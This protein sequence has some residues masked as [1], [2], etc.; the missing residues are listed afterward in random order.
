MKKRIIK[1]CILT[2]CIFMICSCFVYIHADFW[3]DA[4]TWYSASGESGGVSTE[5]GDKIFG[6]LADMINVI[7]TS[8]IVLVTIA[9]GTKYMF[10]S[11]DSKAD[12]K[13]SLINLLVACVFFFGWQSIKA[14][15]I[16]GNNF[17]FT[18]SGDFNGTVGAIFSTS[19]YIL[20]FLVIV[21]VIYV[22]V[23]YI[24]SG[25]SGRG[26]LKAKSG[27]FLIG[28]ILAFATTN[29]LTFLSKIINQMI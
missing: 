10:G 3:S 1:I 11:V 25:A 29:F 6:G 19:M 15:L 27:N 22:G 23:R 14:I 5:E 21:G 8:V 9:L 17:V 2:M 24:F 4:T 20:Q 12:V 7:G 18:S 28:I 16:P 26:E 13:E